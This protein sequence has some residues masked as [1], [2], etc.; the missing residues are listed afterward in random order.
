MNDYPR[1]LI[2]AALTLVAF[3]LA[4][5][6]SA[7]DAPGETNAD[8]AE[9]SGI[10]G[11]DTP[12][13][14]LGNDS[15]TDTP[16]T[17]VAPDL[18]TEDGG[19]D[20][21]TDAPDADEDTGPEDTGPEEG[22][23]GWPC[24]SELDC[25]SGFCIQAEAGAGRVCTD[26]CVGECVHDG[27]DCLP[28]EGIEGGTTVF[29]CIPEAPVTCEPCA[30]DIDCG[31]LAASCIDLV[32]GQWCAL[33]CGPDR[34]CDPGLSCSTELT[35]LGEVD[36]CLPETRVCSEC[37]DPDEDGRGVGAGCPFEGVDCEPEDVAVFPGAAELCDTID[38]DCDERVDEGYDFDHDP[39]HCGG[40]DISC[41]SETATTGCLGGVCQIFSCAEGR[42]DCN[43]RADDGCEADVSLLND[44][45]GCGGLS[46]IP[47]ESCGACGTGR[48]ECDGLDTVRCVGDEGDDALNRCGG[49]SVLDGVPGVRCG[50][51][52][53]GT[54][55]CDGEEA[56]ACAG[57]SGP[58]VLND[59]GGC[60]ELAAAIGDAC[61][62]CSSGEWA[63]NG[64][65][66]V[67]CGGDGGAEA[68]NECGGCAE[69]EEDP[70]IPCGPCSDGL[71]TCNGINVVNC[72]GATAD[73]D[74]DLVC[75]DD[76]VCP[77]GDDRVDSDGDGTPDACDIC[78][79]DPDDDEDEDGVC[80]LDD[81]CPGGDD[82]LDDDSD[83]VPDFCD[84][85]HGGDDRI[86]SDFDLTPDFCDCD[87][88]LCPTAASCDETDEGVL[89]TCD[90]GFREFDGD[91]VDIDECSSDPCG[92]NS[93]CTNT[94]GSFECRCL[95]GYEDIAGTCTDIDECAEGIA[96][97]HSD[98]VCA[99]TD[100]SFTCTCNPGYEGDGRSCTNIDECATGVHG[101]D[102][103]ATCSDTVG[104]FSCTC[105]EGY[106]GDGFTCEPDRF[107]FANTQEIDGR[108]VLCETVD[109]TA[110]YT[111]C[112][113]LTV[114]GMF[115]PN[116][117]SCGPGWSTSNSPST[118]I[119]GFCE[120][121]TGSRTFEVY[122][123]CNSHRPRI[124]WFSGG[125]GTH[126]DN[127]FMPH[128]RCYY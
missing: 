116:G 30:A 2:L 36:V 3:A 24:D 127:G 86:D 95:A 46:G 9:D 25:I 74:G 59:C 23:F 122:L 44:C 65:D 34:T 94:I 91:C 104:S 71:W 54:W 48:Y 123:D 7:D 109:N 38:N 120:S 41:A 87:S 60:S 105:D 5:C 89:C 125:W 79:D 112:N 32:D 47:G 77:G 96:G 16:M 45:G 111:G 43:G 58:G 100:G 22:A 19:R 126:S 39:E 64:S 81:L 93:L 61:G 55:V 103:N 115:W 53:T 76:D 70:G 50:T 102:A 51:C 4:A 12:A 52:E 128:I 83:G 99:N 101:C 28:V 63:C 82:A 75:G 62:T 57:D 13:E 56:V 110:E 69:L 97:C 119:P 67:I 35:E 21:G 85:C 78:P 29:L 42:V 40:C 33:G 92:P 90:P 49:C 73:P 80:F 66:S 18:P 37:W 124:T 8:T 68:R 1:Q 98:A 107:V 26:V 72:I 14:D 11:F 117:I 27:F 17:D 31:S 15:G 108:T 113:N 121:L 88:D 114:D 6:G 118:D 106:S 20:F 10:G 84:V